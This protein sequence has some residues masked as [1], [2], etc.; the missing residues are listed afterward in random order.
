MGAKKGLLFVFIS[1]DS[2]SFEEYQRKK[3]Y[4]VEHEPVE[5]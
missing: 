2:F 4:T 5:E 3:M 1:L